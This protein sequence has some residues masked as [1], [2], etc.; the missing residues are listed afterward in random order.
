[1]ENDANARR[2]ST[3]GLLPDHANDLEARQTSPGN[4]NI[5][6]SP[7]EPSPRTLESAL[8]QTARQDV[9]PQHYT[10]YKRRYLGLF[11]L[12]LLNIIVSWDW[13]TF[14][15]VSTT[16]ADYFQVS[17]T[18][19]NWL[20]TGYLFAF[21]AAAPVTMWTLNVGGPKASIVTAS[22]LTLLGN[23]IRYAGTRSSGGRFGA[24]VFGQIIIGFAQPFVLSAPTR[25]SDLW[26]SDK[27]RVSAT[28][29]AS[30]ANPLGGAVSSVH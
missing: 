13:L 16:A 5:D 3:E 30:L 17:E 7:I 26:F 1:M 28:A 20:S 22:V 15:A 25:Y 24:V 21:V 2:P 8:S 12:V 10:L 23:W 27:G 4:A 18:A 9:R 11:Q 19:I 6:H 14:S 29:V